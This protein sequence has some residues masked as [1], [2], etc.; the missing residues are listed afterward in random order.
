MLDVP[1][2]KEMLDLNQ[3]GFSIASIFGKKNKD[4]GLQKKTDQEKDK[5]EKKPIWTIIKNI[6]KKKK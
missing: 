1:S 4:S 6:F 3:K 5:K 2:Y